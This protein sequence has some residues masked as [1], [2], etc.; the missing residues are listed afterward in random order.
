LL[1]QSVDRLTETM[2]DLVKMLGPIAR[3]EHEMQRAE[4]GVQQAEHFFEFRRREKAAE[5][6]TGPHG[7]LAGA[8]T[9]GRR[10]DAEAGRA[11]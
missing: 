8:A 5:P 2:Q 4:H 11:R 10:S 9:T 3:A 1:T 6:E 7:E